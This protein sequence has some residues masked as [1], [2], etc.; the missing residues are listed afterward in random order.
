MSRASGI[1][2]WP[3]DDVRATVLAVRDLLADDGI[4]YLPELPG[5]GPGADMV[6]R[7]A[8][9]LVDLPVDLQP[10][11]WRFVDR[12]GH[13]QHRTDAFWH[14]DLDEL[15]E[16]YDGYEGDLKIQVA[17]PWTL[18]SAI[19]LNRGERSIADQGAC[20]DLVSSLAEGL[21]LHVQAVQRLVPRSRITIQVDEP[22]LPAALAGRLPTA[23]GFGRLR[24]VDPLVAADGLRDV[25]AAAGDRATLV[26][27]CAR[28]VPLPLL[29]STGAGSVAI[30]ISL[31]DAS[32]WETVA[33]TVESGVGLYAGVTATGVEPRAREVVERLV[34]GW[35]DVGL[36]LSGLDDVILT[37]ACGLAH[38]AHAAAARTLQGSVIEAARVLTDVAHG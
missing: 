11:G 23:S 33:A 18:A 16:A 25:L 14:E 13:D 24:A 17:G 8:A 1:G 30:D 2:S 22:G 36:P 10:S 29:R 27:C 28:D 20:R 19:A 3:G 6:G 38:A 7:T 12:P 9:L 31:L 34:T 32:G 35:R 15:A 26:H 21:R 37:P 4:P 5:R